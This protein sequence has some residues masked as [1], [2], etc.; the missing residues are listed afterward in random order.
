MASSPRHPRTRE[1]LQYLDEQRAV[2][3]TAFDAVPRA[4][5]ELHPSP[6]KW[7]ATG[8]VEHLSIVEARVADRLE[9]AIEEA[10]QN[11]LGPD[12]HLEPILPLVDVLRVAD[13]TNRVSAPE[14]AHPTLLGP[15]E[16]WRDLDRAG[17]RIRELLR[18][19]DGLDLSAVTAVH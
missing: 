6:E 18:S 7:S 16:A 10:R 17:V 13:R 3:R 4:Q 5:V 8:V 11:G 2:L 9:S 14:V 12:P 1:L 15:A 19:A